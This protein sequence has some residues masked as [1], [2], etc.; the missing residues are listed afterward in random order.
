MECDNG[1][2]VS[3]APALK[4]MIKEIQAGAALH[5]QILH[6]LARIQLG[7]AVLVYLKCHPCLGRG[8]C[9]ESGVFL[10]LH[11]CMQFS[12]DSQ[13]PARV[14]GIDGEPETQ[15]YTIDHRAEGT[16][17]RLPL[18]WRRKSF[19]AYAHPFSLNAILGLNQY[20]LVNF[21]I[22]VLSFVFF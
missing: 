5:S 19:G 15:A 8:I 10:S 21:E 11:S 14:E 2:A 16:V 7:L 22:Y 12:D 20:F 3:T 17:L 13:V 18:P 6:P 1:I 4:T 9:M